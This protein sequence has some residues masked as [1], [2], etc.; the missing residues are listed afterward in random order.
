[1]KFVAVN[2]SNAAVYAGGQ[3]C[4]W[5]QTCLLNWKKKKGYDFTL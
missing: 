3:L 2:S 4:Q 1:M 5:E